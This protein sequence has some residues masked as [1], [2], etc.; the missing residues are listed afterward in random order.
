MGES[1]LETV[2]GC[3]SYIES[4]GLELRTH[5][6]DGGWVAVVMMK[7]G[8]RYERPILKMNYVWSELSA[9]R[10]AVRALEEMAGV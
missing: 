8:A 3:K 4:L 9:C 7:S 5:L 2:R 10:A 6:W 1:H